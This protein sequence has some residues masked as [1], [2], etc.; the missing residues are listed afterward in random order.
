LVDEYLAQTLRIRIP[1][2]VVYVVTA[3][4]ID[5]PEPVGA[6]GCELVTSWIVPG[7]TLQT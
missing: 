2:I 1:V 6:H 4:K 5:R 7:L 3:S